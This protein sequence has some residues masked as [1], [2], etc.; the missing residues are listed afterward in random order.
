MNNIHQQLIRES[1][2][3]SSNWKNQ[4]GI[5]IW[6]TEWSNANHFMGSFQST[7]PTAIPSLILDAA[8]QKS[9]SN[10]GGNPEPI[11]SLRICPNSAVA[12]NFAR[13]VHGQLAV[14]LFCGNAYWYK[15]KYRKIAHANYIYP[16]SN[17]LTNRYGG[18]I[19]L[20]K[21][22]KN[23]DD[24]SRIKLDDDDGKI[25]SSWRKIEPIFPFYHTLPKRGS[26]LGLPDVLFSEYTVF[27]LFS[28]E[29]RSI[30]FEKFYIKCTL[31]ATDILYGY[32]R[33]LQ[34]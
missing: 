1:N 8:K 18:A 25:W 13:F 3:P 27:I 5:L 15:N 10:V 2:L 32:I 19:L 9:F 20:I 4:C 23:I 30:I 7:C 24:A 29:M 33:I 22:S 16:A 17:G 31:L 12:F 28:K 11:R 21:R 26:R 6:Q 34:D 14:F